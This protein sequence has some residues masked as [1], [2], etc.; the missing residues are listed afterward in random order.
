MGEGE[1]RGITRGYAVGLIGAVTLL[2]FAL[3]VASWGFIALATG[4]QPVQTESVTFVIA[5]LSIALSLGLL[6]SMLWTSTV[7]LLRGRRTPP[8]SQSVIAGCGAYLI[9]CLVGLLAGMSIGETWASWYAV[10]LALFWAI[11]P[12]LLWAVLSRRVYTDRRPPRWY[13]ENHPA[14]GDLQYPDHPVDPD[15]DAEGR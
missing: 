9:W 15:E 11:A 4:T 3:L 1:R 2:S 6:V 5:P 13:W 10:V 8:L 12:L 14:P 7:A